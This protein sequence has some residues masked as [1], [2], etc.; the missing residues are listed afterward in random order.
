MILNLKGVSMKIVRLIMLYFSLSI[1][2]LLCA[3][4]A[5]GPVIAIVPEPQMQDVANQPE[6]LF[7]RDNPWQYLEK[8]LIKF[9][10]IKAQEVPQEELEQ[11]S[12]NMK[13]FFGGAGLG[14]LIGTLIAFA[15]WKELRESGVLIP[16]VGVF[17]GAFVSSF[18]TKHENFRKN[19]NIEALNNFFENYRSELVPQELRTSFDALHALY[20]KNQEAFID[21]GL[22]VYWQARELIYKHN[23]S[24]YYP[25]VVNVTANSY[26]VVINSNW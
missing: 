13:L 25:P 23:P 1:F 10:K 18:F 20:L 9:P 7:Y 16:L 8:M 14:A 26:P 22:K 6:Y 12:R 15:K 21:E 3:E 17:F 2:S 5:A 19:C 4:A 24:K 11:L